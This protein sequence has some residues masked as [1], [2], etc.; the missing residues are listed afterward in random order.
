MTP[1]GHRIVTAITVA[2]AVLIITPLL[3]TYMHAVFEGRRTFLSPILRPVEVRRLPP[4][5]ASTRPRSRAGRATR[6]RCSLFSIVSILVL[7]AL[8]RLQAGCHSTRPAWA[9]YAG[10]PG[11]NTAVSFV[12]NT[13]WQ[14][15]S[16]ETTMTH[17]TQAAGL[18]VQN[19][20]SRRGRHR[21]RDRA[22]PRPRP[23]HRQHDR[24]LLGRPDPGVRLRAAADRRRRRRCSWSRRASSRRWAGPQDGHDHRRRAADHR[25]GPDRVPGD[26]SRS[27]APTAAAS[28]TPTPRIR[29]ENP[30][31]LT[32]LLQMLSI[33]VIP[34]G[35][36]AT[37]GRFAEDRAPGLDDLRRDV[38]RSWSSAPAWR[39]ACEGGGN[40]LYPAGIDQALG[41]HGGQGDPLRRAGR[42]LCRRRHHGHQH[43]CRQRDA[44]PASRRSADWS[45][46]ST[47][48]SARSR[49]AAWARASTGC[50]C[51]RSCRCSSPGLMV[52]RTPEYLGKKIESFEMKMAMIVVLVLAASVLG[53]HGPRDDRRAG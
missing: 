9:R 50:S 22:H 20:A 23:S 8:Q 15:Y 10:V 1:P 48:C 18:A 40:A 3:G 4:S 41:Q 2:I 11:F 32:N 52:G 29:F 42:R 14:N 19:F 28:S 36:T 26:A 12:T 13:N 49:P 46:C 39:W 45:R 43:R 25:A 35:L 21:G 16:G 17:L 6:S 31:G 7:Y 24:Q 44:L 27:W 53:Y 51:S 47:C 30:T 34:F 5:H 38:P 33:L 37:F